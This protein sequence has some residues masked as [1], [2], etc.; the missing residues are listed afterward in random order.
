MG[1]LYALALPV[2]IPTGA[3]APNNGGGG[4]GLAGVFCT[5][6]VLVGAAT[7]DTTDLDPIG[8]AL[9]MVFDPIPMAIVVVTLATSFTNLCESMLDTGE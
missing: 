5:G 7:G 1:G 4:G 6:D 3:P 8:V 9:D 2:D